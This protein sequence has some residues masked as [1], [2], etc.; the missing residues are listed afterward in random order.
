MLDEAF[1]WAIHNFNGIAKTL[2]QM[3]NNIC[4]YKIVYQNAC[5][6]ILL[7]FVTVNI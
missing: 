6:F 1:E 4:I 2:Y 5:G 7:C 3:E